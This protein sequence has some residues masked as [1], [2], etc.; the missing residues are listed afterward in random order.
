MK[1]VNIYEA[2]T[3][4]SKLIEE[5]E[6]GDT[7]TIARNGKPVAILSSYKKPKNNIPFGIWANNKDFMISPDFDA[8]DPEINALFYGDN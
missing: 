4:F 5:I 2:K 6:G 7:I 8:P 3:T 1:T